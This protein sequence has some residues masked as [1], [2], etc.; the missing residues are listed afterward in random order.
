MPFFYEIYGD[1]PEDG[2][3]LFISMHGGGGAPKRVNDRQWENQK[4][5]YQPA[6]GVYLSPR[7]PTDTW[8]LWHQPHIDRLFDRLI[9]DLIVL[10]DVNPNRVYI[11]GYSAGGDGVYQLAPRMA[12]R[13]AAAAMMAGHPNDASPLGLR[14]LPFTIHVGG[15]DGAYNRNQVAQEWADQLAGLHEREPAGYV[16]WVKIYEGKG[17]WLDREDAAAIPWMAKFERNPCPTSLVWKQDDVTGNRFYWLAVEDGQAKPHVEVRATIDQQ[18][19][20]I[21]TSDLQQLLVRLDDR[22]VNMNE[23]VEITING[24]QVFH[25]I[26][27]RTIEA[28]ARTLAERGDPN[29][30][31][32]GEVTVTCPDKK[33]ETSS[34]WWLIPRRMVQTNLRE[35]DATMDLDRYVQE[36]QDSES[37]VVLFNVGGIVANYPT[38]AEEPLPEPAHERRPGR[39]RAESPACRGDSHDRPISI[40]ARSI[41]TFA[42]RASRMAVRQRKGRNTSTTTVRCI[43]ASAADTSRSTCLRFSARRSIAIRWTACSST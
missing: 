21:H 3:S 15:N 16:H 31:F 23:A 35:I 7:A 30:V 6:E 22:L 8:N 17:H 41:E 43:P 42:E 26:V 11:M 13:L 40:S 19:L 25:G 38:Q 5:L 18:Q 20:K 14:N 1:K 2:R 33:A 12:D 24:Q 39:H 36:V 27:P 34:P 10:E 9:E 32:S 37:S 29:A 28:L 4:R